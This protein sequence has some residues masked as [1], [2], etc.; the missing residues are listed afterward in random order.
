VCKNNM[1]CL[2][3]VGLLALSALVLGGCGSDADFR[4][5]HRLV[6]EVQWK[7]QTRSKKLQAVLVRATEKRLESLEIPSRVRLLNGSRLEVKIPT[8]SAEML[9]TI[10]KVLPVRGH[11]EFRIV[12]NPN[13]HYYLI[14]TSLD[15]KNEVDNVVYEP[16]DQS[17]PDQQRVAIGY[18]AKVGRSATKIDGEYPLRAQFFFE[19]IRDANTKQR[20]DSNRLPGDSHEFSRWL[21]K[22]GHKEIE[23]L[24]SVNDGYE[25][26]NKHLK[27]VRTS[28]DV[29][30]RPTVSFVMTE[31]G[32]KQIARLTKEYRPTDRGKFRL[33]ILLDGQLITAPTI[34]SVIRERGEITGNFTKSEVNELVAVLNVRP[35]PAKLVAD[36]IE[37]GP[38]EDK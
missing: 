12:A 34:Q 35:L 6:Y 25:L 23:V 38:F 11:L 2:K 22:E 10:R 26:G 30:G 21:R 27:S 16:V 9:A 3:V 24:V 14:E 31:R 28:F 5:G 1:R 7:G 19:P 17:E 29:N 32:A 18:W 37:D 8:L 4:K 13:E 36:P 33:A 20:I 15:E